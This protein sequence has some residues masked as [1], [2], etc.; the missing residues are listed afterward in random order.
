MCSLQN[1]IPELSPEVTMGLSTPGISRKVS[2][3]MQGRCPFTPSEKL[4]NGERS[5]AML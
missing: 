5:E 1:H 2:G 3:L 4:L